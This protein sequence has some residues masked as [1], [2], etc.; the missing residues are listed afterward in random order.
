MKRL[1]AA[2]LSLALA[3][4]A[5]A[6]VREVTECIDM[7]DMAE[8]WEEFEEIDADRRD[9]VDILPAMR[10][11]PTDGLPLP[12]RL[13]LR[14]ASGEVNFPILADGTVDADVVRTVHANGGGELCATDPA[15]AGTD[16]DS[17]GVEVRMGLLPQV[18]E[19]PGT[20]SLAQLEKGAKDGRKFFKKMAPGAFSFLVPKLDHYAVSHPTDDST[21]LPTVRAFRGEDDLGPVPM[22]PFDVSQLM[23]L[24]A[25]EDMGADRIVVTGPYRLFP[26]PDAKT[27]RRFMS[28]D[29]SE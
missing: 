10:M 11:E 3:T 27:V 21:Q 7:K 15:R 6:D 19:R 23:S 29:D 24:E 22:E 9:V 17:Y 13:F 4:P 14:T 2:L 8:T 18:V 5:F 25:L 1:P 28:D 26:M 20:H 12:E 16:K